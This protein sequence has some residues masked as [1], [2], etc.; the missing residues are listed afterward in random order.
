MGVMSRGNQHDKAAMMESEA[1]RL[2]AAMESGAAARNPGLLNRFVLLTFAGMEL[3]R[4]L[5][6]ICMIA[7]MKDKQI[8][9]YMQG[10]TWTSA[11]TL[12]C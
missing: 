2:L 8:Y 4:Q 6:Q 12:F 3:A 7:L 10:W 9:N 1:R 5:M 11:M